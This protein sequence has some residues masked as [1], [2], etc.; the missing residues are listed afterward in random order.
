MLKDGRGCEAS[1]TR[2]SKVNGRSGC[3]AVTKGVDRNMWVTTSKIA[4]PLG[5]G[6]AMAAEVMGVCV[7]TSILDLALHTSLR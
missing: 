5:V 4:V 3:G 2:S 1:G 7:L 6:T